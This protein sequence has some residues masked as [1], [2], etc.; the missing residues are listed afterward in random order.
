MSDDVPWYVSL[1]IAWLPL[2]MFVSAV[3]WST[4]RLRTS[5][6]TDDG[7]SLVQVV[8]DV[9]EEMKRVNDRRW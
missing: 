6:M 8:G 1:I 9:A 3:V 7:R 4:R 2:I 5:L